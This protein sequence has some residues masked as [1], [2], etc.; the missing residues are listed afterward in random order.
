[1]HAAEGALVKARASALAGAEAC[2]SR[3][4]RI[5][6]ALA[7]HDLARLG[8]ARDAAARLARL[9]EHVQGPMVRACAD[10]AAALVDRNG[11]ALSGVAGAFETIGSPLLA[12]EALIEASAVF[13]ADGR[14][15]SARACA[16]RAQALLAHCPGARTPTLATATETSVLTE[17][18]REIAVLAAAGLSNRAIAERLVVSVRTVENQLQRSYGKLGINSR[19]ELAALLGSSR[20]QVE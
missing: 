18:E 8:G 1:M 5:A 10:H 3:G 7:F 16:S 12:A 14:A 6:G 11:A 9:A 19:R 2:D 17:R 20:D 4:Q 15:S 13:G